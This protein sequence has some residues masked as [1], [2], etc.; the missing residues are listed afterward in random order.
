MPP[1]ETLEVDRLTVTFARDGD[2]SCADV[3]FAIAPGEAFGLV[4]E[5]GRA[6]A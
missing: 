5:S 3:S 1:R 6:R 4:G 2:P